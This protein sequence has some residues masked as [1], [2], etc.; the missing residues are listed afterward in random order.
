MYNGGEAV[1][2]TQNQN[3]LIKEKP[4]MGLGK[5]SLRLPLVGGHSRKRLRVLKITVDS[6]RP[7]HGS[8]DR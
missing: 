1:Q 5:I 7:S 8:R 2:K 4:K 3:L 6:E